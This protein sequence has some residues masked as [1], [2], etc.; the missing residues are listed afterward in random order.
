MSSLIEGKREVLYQ[1]YFTLCRIT[2]PDG[3]IREVLEARDSVAALV[4]VADRDEVL[5]VEQTRVPAHSATNPHGQIV[6]LVAGRIDKSLSL[7]E[8]LLEEL[9]EELGVTATADNIQWMNQREP[10]TL[11]AGTITEK[12]YVAYVEVNSSQ[13]DS[14]DRI[15][16]LAEA[17]ERI[18][19]RW[20]SR[21]D[22]LTM[23]CSDLR[24]LYMQAWF[25]NHIQGATHEPRR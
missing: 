22:F 12:A 18:T 23:V 11:S 4:Y 14:E 13:V 17:N 9:I 16:G 21:E 5:L 7:D 19:R 24:V 15:Y 3:H 1:G 25:K 10:V 8:I 20:I 6:E 2:Y